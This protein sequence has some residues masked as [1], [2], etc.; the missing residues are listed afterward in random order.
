VFSLPLGL[1]RDYYYKKTSSSVDRQ[2]I[3]KS[4]LFERVSVRCMRYALENLPLDMLKV[5]L[6]TP[7][8]DDLYFFTRV[9]PNS[10]SGPA[11]IQIDRQTIEVMV[12]TWTVS[13]HDLKRN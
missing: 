6:S 5:F 8:A 7:V 2:F 10:H 12:R 11:D 9:L 1:V 13:V 4:T 3:L